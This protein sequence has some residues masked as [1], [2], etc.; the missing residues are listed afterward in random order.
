MKFKKGIRRDLL[1]LTDCYFNN[2]L[3]EKLDIST[4]YVSL[5]L[6]GERDF[7]ENLRNEIAK[8]ADMLP[9]EIEQTY[10]VIDPE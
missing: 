2:E 10:C 5:I 7:S 9:T 6:N 3:A 1:N 4:N 8:L